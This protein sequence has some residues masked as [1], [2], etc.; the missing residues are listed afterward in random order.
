MKIKALKDCKWLARIYFKNNFRKFTWA[1]LTLD[2]IG[3]ILLGDSF[4]SRLYTTK[5]GAKNALL[6]FIEIN[7]LKNVEI[8]E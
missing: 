1:I 6:R 5:H 2:P 3:A 8:M 4:H 7:E